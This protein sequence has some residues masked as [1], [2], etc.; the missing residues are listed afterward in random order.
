MTRTWLPALAILLTSSCASGAQRADTTASNVASLPL[1]ELTPNGSRAST[2]AIFLTGDGGWAD[3]DRKVSSV[4]A[5]H[6]I[7]VV[8]LNM[9]SYLSNKKT[10]E[11]TAADVERVARTYMARWKSDR[12]V[13]V[14]YSRGADI[15]PFVANRLPADLRAR[16]A[17][18]A[19]L[20]LAKATNFHLHLIDLIKDVHRPDDVPVAPELERLRGQRMLCVYGTEEKDSGCRAADST[21]ITKVERKGGHHFDGDYRGLGELIVQMLA[22]PS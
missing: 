21:L 3:L 14:G 20:G 7:G 11:Q 13:L 6:G 1:V 2:T 12:L 9:R 8:G 22:P 5:E 17:A 15:L 16:V 19:M 4:L 18:L 10:P